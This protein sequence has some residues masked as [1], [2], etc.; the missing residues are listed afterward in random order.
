MKIFQH[1]KQKL[2]ARTN[3]RQTG[4]LEKVCV[5]RAY[6]TFGRSTFNLPAIRFI[7]LAG[8]RISHNALEAGGSAHVLKS[9]CKKKSSDPF[10]MMSG[11]DKE[12]V[13]K[14]ILHPN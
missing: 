7:E 5:I 12:V 13:D 6:G 1:A 11:I 4:V 10:P 14:V 3:K 2:L 9:F 8:F